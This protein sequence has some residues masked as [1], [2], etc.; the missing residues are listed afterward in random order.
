VDVCGR[1]ISSLRQ[2]GSRVSTMLDSAGLTTKLGEAS[3]SR[4]P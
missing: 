4:S 1:R 2:Y 3:R